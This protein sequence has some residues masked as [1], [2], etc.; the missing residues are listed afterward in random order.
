MMSEPKYPASEGLQVYPP[1]EE[2]ADL[3]VAHRDEPKYY[4]ENVLQPPV[5]GGPRRTICGL[6]KRIFWGLVI[7][8]I[9]VVAAVAGGVGGALA[10]KKPSSSQR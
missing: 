10:S 7:A 1:L 6:R 2:H 3:E 4:I 9:V 8:A 5:A